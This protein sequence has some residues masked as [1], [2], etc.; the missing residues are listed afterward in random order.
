MTE[1]QGGDEPS[2][3]ETGPKVAGLLREASSTKFF[4]DSTNVFVIAFI[5]G[6][7]AA[8]ANGIG[9]RNPPCAVEQ[10]SFDSAGGAGRPEPEEGH[11]LHRRPQ[12]AADHDG[13]GPGAPRRKPARPC[14]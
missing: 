1:W 14:L 10:G 3:N 5:D 6:P 7:Q 8:K 2:L 13:Q 11:G 12:A 4:V 9:T